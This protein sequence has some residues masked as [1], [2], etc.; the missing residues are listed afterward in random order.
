MT[1]SLGGTS[2]VLA[3]SFLDT[4]EHLRFEAWRLFRR[5]PFRRLDEERCRSPRF[6]EDPCQRAAL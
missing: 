5:V 4:R 3:A 2:S 6:L 1:L